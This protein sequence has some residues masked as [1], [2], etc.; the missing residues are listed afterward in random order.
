MEAELEAVL[1]ALKE[2]DF[3]VAVKKN[4]SSAGNGA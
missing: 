2:Y 3:H 1:N 4:G